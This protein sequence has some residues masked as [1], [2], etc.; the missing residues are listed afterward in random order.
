MQKGAFIYLSDKKDGIE[1]LIFMQVDNATVLESFPEKNPNELKEHDTLFSV[2]YDG[3]NTLSSDK[4][5]N[6]IMKITNNKLM[7]NLLTNSYNQ[8]LVQ[9]PY[10]KYNIY[11]SLYNFTASLLDLPSISEEEPDSPY[12]IPSLGKMLK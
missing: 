12:T 9:L 4:F 5:E 8:I 1:L 11:V 3:I 2:F 7:I 10:L 6:F